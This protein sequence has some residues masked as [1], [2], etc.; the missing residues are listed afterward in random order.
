MTDAL[1]AD[2]LNIE[3]G[4]LKIKFDLS[5]VGNKIMIVYTDIYGNDFTESFDVMGVKIC[6]K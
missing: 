6:K 2:E 5:S 1:F 3:D 4:V